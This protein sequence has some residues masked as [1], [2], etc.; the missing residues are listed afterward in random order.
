MLYYTFT[1]N[2]MIRGYHIYKD[3]WEN[4]TIGEE[5]CCE[6]EVGNPKDP[7]AIAV[8][9]PI[10]GE[11]TVIGH[12]CTSSL[13]SLFIRRGGAIKCSINGNR[14]YSADLP[15]GGME[16]LCK[17]VFSSKSIVDSEKLKKLV[18]AS[19]S[20][21]KVLR[22]QKI[23]RKKIGEMCGFAKFAKLLSYTVVYCNENA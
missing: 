2:S 11:N 21:A 12:V 5:L 4:P 8:I 17:F 16:I 10:A 22:I 18:L 7:L 6:R 14:R 19:L 15:Q 20:E 9:K 1:V 23:C 3:I 13:C